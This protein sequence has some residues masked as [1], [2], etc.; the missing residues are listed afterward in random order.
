[1]ATTGQRDEAELLAAGEPGF[2]QP[3]LATLTDA[4]PAGDDWSYEL[5]LDGY[6]LV[7]VRDGATVTLWTRNRLDRTGAFPEVAEALVA[8]PA[9]RFVVDGEV[10]AFDGDAPS[11]SLLQRRAGLSDPRLA[12]AS[13][14][15]V[16][17]VVFDLLHL[18]GVDVERLP[19][20]RRCQFLEGAFHLD[21]PLQ[22]S[23][24]LTGGADELLAGACRDGWEGLIAKR[25]GSPYRPGRSRDWLKLKCVSRQELVIGGW[26]DPQGARSGFGALLVGFHDEDGRLTFAGKVGTGYDQATLRDLVGRLGPLARTTSP[27]VVDSPR[28]RGLHWVEPRLVAEVAFGEWTATGK[29]RHP[30]FLGLRDDKDPRHVGRERPEV[31]P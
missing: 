14:V 5:K 31:R 22:G 20:E 24:A 10:V 6:R 9:T 18:N 1:M 3:M 11:F 16:R 15:E 12:R 21:H 13:G 28:G 26:T 27:F 25:L 30:R 23:T 19:L 17:F 2:R 29:L 8:Q 7:A 4:P